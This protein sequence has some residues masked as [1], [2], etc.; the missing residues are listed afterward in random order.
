MN[1]INNKISRLLPLYFE[2]KL[3]DTQVNEVRVW[4]EK[5]DDNKAIANDMADIYCASDTLFAINNIDSDFALKTVR[6]KIRQSRV[7]IVFV[8]VE[9][10]AA[11]LFIPLL[12]VVLF[13]FYN[14]KCSRPVDMIA[15]STSPGVTACTT[16]P[17]GTIVKLNSNSHLKYPSQFV[18]D[19]REISLQGEAYFKVTKDAR[20]PFIV[21]TPQQTAIKVYGTHF[22][23]EAYQKDNS[24]IAT[25]EEGSISMKYIDSRNK[26]MECKIKPGESITYSKKDKTISIVK[27]NVD[28]VTS[29]KDNRLIFMDTPFKDVLHELSKRFSVDFYV[30]N[31]KVYANSF[32]GT[33]ENQRLDRIMEYLNLTS[34]MHF[35]YMSNKD[36]NK[37]KQTIEIY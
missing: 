21:N 14:A 10:I 2:G 20:H 24:V 8:Y 25:L 19:K 23:V 11:V 4:I 16:L 22:D 15:L 6:S 28:V 17:D 32:T 3:D 7:H 36:I 26:Q 30:R 9:R 13:Q 37:Q 1:D 27:V 31:P 12:F 5:S 29:W 34:G 33:L 35:R 18:N